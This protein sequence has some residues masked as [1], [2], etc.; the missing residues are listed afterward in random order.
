MLLL[1]FT[2][3]DLVGVVEEDVGGHEGWVSEE[4]DADEF[5]AFG[6]VFILGH[7]VEL[8]DGAVAT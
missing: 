8:T 3:R 7:A 1:V 4:A 5:F 2:D 6:F